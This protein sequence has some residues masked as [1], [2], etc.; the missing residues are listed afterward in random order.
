MADRDMS[1]S[2]TIDLDFPFDYKGEKITSITLRRPKVRDSIAV[3]KIKGGE[4]QRGLAMIANLADREPEL[5]HELDDVDL[6]KVQAQ[7]LA[8]TGRQATTP[9]N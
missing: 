4:F 3:D 7:Y 8:F 9:E 5:L 1:T 2:A 6:E